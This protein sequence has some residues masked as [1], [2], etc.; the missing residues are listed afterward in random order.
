MLAAVDRLWRRI[1]PESPLDRDRRHAL[2]R[3]VIAVLSGLAS[4]V[5]LQGP[6]PRV[7]PDAEI[8]LLKAALT[9]ELADS[10]RGG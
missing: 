8:G 9:R 5:M 3:Y 6:R 10:P 7:Q 2:E 4:S 1:F